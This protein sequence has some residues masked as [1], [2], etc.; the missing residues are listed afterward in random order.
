MVQ[1]LVLVEQSMIDNVRRIK[2]IYFVKG[3][4][5]ANGGSFKAVELFSFNEE[6]SRFEFVNH[7]EELISYMAAK[8]VQ[9]SFN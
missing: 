8:G 6:N 5:E 9:Y 7:C 4:D 1:I 2:K 3:F